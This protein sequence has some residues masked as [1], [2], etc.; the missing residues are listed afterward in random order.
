MAIKHEFHVE[1]DTCA[2]SAGDAGTPIP[3][4]FPAEREAVEDAIEQGWHHNRAT[5]VLTCPACLDDMA[6]DT[7]DPAAAG[8]AEAALPWEQRVAQAIRATFPAE[9]AK[10][11]VADDAIGALTYWL[12]QRCADTGQTPRQALQAIDP[13]DRAFAGRA[14]Q[15]AAFLAAKVRDS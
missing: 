14:D 13:D 11:I 2:A 9:T 12:R 4:T 7:E 10:E 5:N 3:A 15:P 6:G 1:C 8:D